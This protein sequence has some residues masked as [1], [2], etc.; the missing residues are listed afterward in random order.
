[1][2][3]DYDLANW[4]RK[5]SPKCEKFEWQVEE[6]LTSANAPSMWFKFVYRKKKVFIKVI[7][8]M[9]TKDHSLTKPWSAFIY[10]Q[11]I[12]FD[13]K[14]KRRE[15]FEERNIST[16]KFVILTEAIEVEFERSHLRCPRRCFKSMLTSSC[17]H[18][19]NLIPCYYNL[20]V[21]FFCVYSNL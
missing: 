16:T 19:L 7:E 1:M 3:Y 15:R 6:S 21:G 11:L 9:P 14:R 2:D 12:Y 8:L 17:L 5:S 4:E 20:L 10:Y 18:L 13:S